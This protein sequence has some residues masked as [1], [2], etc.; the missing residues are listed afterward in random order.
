MVVD[1][2]AGKAAL[3]Y[4]DGSAYTYENVSSPAIHNLLN[5]KDLSVGEWINEHL[6][7][8]GVSCRFLAKLDV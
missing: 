3:T 4:S 2:E 8:G 5:D 6:K 7:R 1:P